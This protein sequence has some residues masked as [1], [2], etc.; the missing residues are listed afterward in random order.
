MGYSVSI[1]TLPE[2]LELWA[3]FLPTLCLSFPFREKEIIYIVE[4]FGADIGN[5]DD[6]RSKVTQIAKDVMLT[7]IM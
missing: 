7:C 4:L 6:Q 2:N 5:H 1:P 3:T